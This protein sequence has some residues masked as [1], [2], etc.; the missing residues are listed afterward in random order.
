M[1]NVHCIYHVLRQSC[2]V[3]AL[4]YDV[5]KILVATCKN[6]S[7]MRHTL[8]LQCLVCKDKS[9]RTLLGVKGSIIDECVV[10]KVS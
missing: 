1:Y 3:M 10:D 8:V 6:M 9:I 5:L 2:L 7:Y 4:A